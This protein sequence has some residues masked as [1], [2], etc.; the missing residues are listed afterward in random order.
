MSKISREC[1]LLRLY[2][3][4][5]GLANKNSFSHSMKILKYAAKITGTKYELRG[6]EQLSKE[7]TCVIVANHQSAI[8]LIGNLSLCLWGI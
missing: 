2:F 3:D 6:G 4:Y 5:G 7:R 1:F 8:D